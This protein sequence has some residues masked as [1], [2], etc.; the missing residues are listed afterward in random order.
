MT[1]RLLDFVREHELPH[2]SGI[3]MVSILKSLGTTIET[4]EGLFSH[5]YG[6]GSFGEFADDFAF[7]KALFLDEWLADAVAAG[8][9]TSEE[10]QQ[11]LADQEAHAS[12]GRFGL[13]FPL[14]RV[15]AAKL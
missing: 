14:F 1:R 5:S 11:W 12:E 4:V 6:F 15:K 13:G 10:A 9:L 8:V 2:P 7:V 3:E